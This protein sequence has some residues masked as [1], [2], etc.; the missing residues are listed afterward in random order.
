MDVPPLPA[1]IS[2]GEDP[3]EGDILYFILLEA[4]GSVSGEYD[5]SITREDPGGRG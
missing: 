3:L 1:A 4:L 2:D 5:Y